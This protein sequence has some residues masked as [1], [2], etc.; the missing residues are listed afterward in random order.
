MNKIK[1]I[2]KGQCNCCANENI[3]LKKCKTKQCDYSMCSHCYDKYYQTNTLCPACRQ[4]VETNLCKI[5]TNYINNE[6]S[7]S[8]SDD[9]DIEN[10]RLPRYRVCC[11]CC[12]CFYILRSNNNCYC[13]Y[14]ISRRNTTNYRY[15]LNKFKECFINFLA[16]L[17]LLIALCLCI[18][19]ILTIGRLM[20]LFTSEVFFP[21][22][23][24]SFLTNDVIFLILSCLLGLLFTVLWF[25][26]IFCNGVIILACAN[27]CF[28]D[29]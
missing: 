20:Y 29:D 24:Q 21:G 23:E 10:N 3:Y 16:I 22:T 18:T 17:A 13:L 26:C 6:Y 14:E 11:N 27:S 15:Y 9:E 1:P 4:E 8:D 19:L 5:L 12:W 28:N 25:Y 7:E 2:E